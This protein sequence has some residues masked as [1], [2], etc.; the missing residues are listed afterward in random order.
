MFYGHEEFSLETVEFP[1]SQVL[2]YWLEEVA[3]EG[4]LD[5]RYSEYSGQQ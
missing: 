2:L 5:G 4:E 3:P 1:L